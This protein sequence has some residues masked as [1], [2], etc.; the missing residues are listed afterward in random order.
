LRELS[1]AS[2]SGNVVELDCVGY[3]LNRYVVDILV[4]ER[5]RKPD[6]VS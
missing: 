6:S 1:E 4:V 5:L 3:I 2:R